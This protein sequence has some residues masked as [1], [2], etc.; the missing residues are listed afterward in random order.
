MKGRSFSF[1]SK[2]LFKGSLAITLSQ[3]GSKLAGFLLLPLFTTYL[4]EADYGIISM[5]TLVISVVAIFINPGI[6]SAITRI[7]FEIEEEDK[8]ELFATGYTWF[9][10]M[11]VTMIILLCLCGEFLFDLLFNDFDFY[12]YGLIAVIVAL[13]SAI[14]RY[15]NKL[16]SLQY[17]MQRVAVFSLSSVIINLLISILLIV[18][19]SY[20]AM[21]R[22]LGMVAGAS[23]LYSISNIDFFRACNRKL[24]STR[25]LKRVLGYGAKLSMAVWAYFILNL[26]DRYMI[27]V[28]A[29]LSQLGLYQVGYTLA[30]TPLLVI[31]GAKA[32]WNN[33][34]F[35]TLK[36]KNLKTTRKLNS[37]FFVAISIITL[38]TLLFGKELTLVMTN[39]KFHSVVTILP[40][41]TIGIFFM[42]LQI[43]PGG[44][45]SFDKKFTTLSKIAVVAA[46]INIVLNYFWIPIFGI[47][48]AAMSTLFAYMYFFMGASVKTE[49]WKNKLY[50]MP[51]WLGVCTF[52]GGAFAYI[53]L[54]STGS[55]S[56]QDLIIKLIIFTVFIGGIFTKF[57]IKDFLL[58][59]SKNRK[60]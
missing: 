41:I 28:M 48:G 27:E 38:G 3:L 49:F 4:S 34:I 60:K 1:Y 44:L 25:F 24:F 54:F 21:G 56:A 32:L 15:W 12:P 33:I 16:M 59:A 6:V 35:D 45:L 46:I 58:L 14:S 11:S 19:F 9:T 17:N 55:F 2:E 31:L 57:N 51:L 10:V 8:P 43:I 29:D 7:Y 42:S 23:L 40:V 5:F 37:L 52:M 50:N 36:T 30:S 39:D 13:F 26:F 53:M 18:W 20:G 22:V 47:M